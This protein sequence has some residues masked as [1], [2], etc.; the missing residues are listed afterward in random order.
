[1]FSQGVRNSFQINGIPEHDSRSEQIEA[2]GP[3]TLLLEAAVAD[4]T[5]SVEEDSS[6]QRIAGFPL[7]QAGMDSSTLLDALQPVQDKQGALDS[8]QLTQRYRQ[9]VLARIA[10]EFAQHQ[11]GRHCALLDRGC[12]PQDFVPVAANLL[13]VQGALGIKDL[14]FS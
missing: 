2:A 1:V 11:R 5:Q 10:A 3:V 6:G 8:P 7:V 14:R 4:L 12:Q 9:A 13:D